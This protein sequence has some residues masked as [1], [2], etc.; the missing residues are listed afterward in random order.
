MWCF[1]KVNGRLAEIY[2]D[3]RGRGMKINNH[4]YVKAEEFKTKQE[5]RWIKEDTER[6]KFTYRK[7]TYQKKKI[8]S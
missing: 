3:R 5:Q 2:F 4:C 7:G 6:L 1:A 8:T